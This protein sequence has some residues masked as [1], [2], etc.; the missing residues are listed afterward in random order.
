MIEKPG[1]HKYTILEAA[2]YDQGAIGFLML[3][4]ISTVGSRLEF[5]FTLYNWNSS[6]GLAHPQKQWT[7]P[8]T[9]APGKYGPIGMYIFDQANVQWRSRAKG[10]DLAINGTYDGSSAS[11]INYAALVKGMFWGEFDKLSLWKP[12]SGMDVVKVIIGR[13]D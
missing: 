12:A 9:L 6:G 11:A 4:C 7:D 8:R 10:D 13:W 5:D 2:G 1:L 3:N